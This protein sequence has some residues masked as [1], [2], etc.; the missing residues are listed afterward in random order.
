MTRRTIQTADIADAAITA[1]KLTS[2]AHN[3]WTS[4]QGGTSGEYYHTTAAQ[5]TIVATLAAGTYTPSLTNTTNVAASSAYVCQYSRVGNVVTV[6]GLVQIDTTSTGNTVLGMSLPIASNLP[7][8]TEL[9]GV[10]SQTTNEVC[11]IIGDPTNDRALFTFSATSTS[12]T[13]WAFIFMYQVL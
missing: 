9:G 11:R 2:T 4:K 10:A 3:D 12:V 6:S 13:N 7:N 5:N 8:A 1:A